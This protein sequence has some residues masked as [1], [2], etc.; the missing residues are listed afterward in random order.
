M[1]PTTADDV[2]ADLGDDVDVVLDGGPC[3]SASSRRSSTA[4]A[5]R[6]RSCGSEA[7]R[8]SA[9]EDDARSRGRGSGRRF[10]RA[11]GTLPSHY[12]PRARVRDRRAGGSSRACASRVAARRAGRRRRSDAAASTSRRARSSLGTPA[13]ADD[14]ARVALPVRCAPPTTM[15]STCCS[16]CRRPRWASARRSPTGC[17]APARRSRDAVS[18]APIGVFDSGLGG[19]TVLARAHRPAPRRAHHL[20]RRHRPVP[21]R[22][23]AARGGAEVRARDHRRA[24]RARREGARGRVQQRRRPPRSTRSTSDSTSPSSGVIEPG[25]RAACAATQTGRIGVIGTVGTIASGAYQRAAAGRPGDRAHVRRV[26]R[27]RRV[28]RGRRRRLRPGPRARRAPAGAPAARPKSTRSCS[29]ARTTRSSPVRSATSWGGMSCSSR[30]PT[31]PRS[32]SGT[33]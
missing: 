10:G 11:P 27:L 30:A 23:E 33:S 2:R 9:I 17:G 18:D 31:R 25:L 8:A 15:V 16:R 13:D 7:S 20:L 24:A 5:G 1:S 12:A 29:V 28:R 4:R 21:V 19:L 14:Y 6:P 26:S 22:A 3:R 32:P